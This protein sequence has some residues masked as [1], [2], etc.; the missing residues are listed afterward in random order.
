L[1]PVKILNEAGFNV[2]WKGL[3][4]IIEKYH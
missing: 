2:R 4:L 1:E 3:R